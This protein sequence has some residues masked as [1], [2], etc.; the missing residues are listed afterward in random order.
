LHISKE[1]DLFAYAVHA[2]SIPGI[3]TRHENIDIVTIRERS[4]GEYS[5]IEHE[6]Y[7]GVI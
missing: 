2:F 5:A 7:P 1:L 4:E 3:K 6:V